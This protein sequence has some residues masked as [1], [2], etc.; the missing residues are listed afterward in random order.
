MGDP[1]I[2]VSDPMI[3][4]LVPS[5]VCFPASGTHAPGTRAPKYRSDAIDHNLRLTLQRSK[6]ETLLARHGSRN[7]VCRESNTTSRRDARRMK[8]IHQ[9]IVMKQCLPEN[10]ASQLHRFFDKRKPGLG[11]D[12][13]AGESHSSIDNRAF[14]TRSS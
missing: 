3:H 4:R 9:S 5:F 13:A 8:S 11:T 6:R 2:S 14:S 1:M 12:W 10:R 7:G